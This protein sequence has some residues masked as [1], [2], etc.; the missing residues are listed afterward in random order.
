MAIPGEGHKAV[1]DEQKNNRLKSFHCFIE[2]IKSNLLVF[3]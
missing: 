3:I 2:L 1:G